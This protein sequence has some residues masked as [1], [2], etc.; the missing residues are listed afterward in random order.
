[1]ISIQT[2][3]ALNVFLEMRFIFAFICYLLWLSLI[4]QDFMG[5][6]N[7]GKYDNTIQVK[8]SDKATVSYQNFA[9]SNSFYKI[10]EP[11]TINQTSSL[12]FKISISGHKDTIIHRSYHFDYNYKFPILSI[13]IDPED[14]WNDTTGIYVKGK[15]AYW[16]DS[17]GHWENCNYQKKW[18]KTV[19]ATFIDT[20]NVVGFSQK[21]GLKIFGESTR[22]QPDKSMKIIARSEFGEGKFNYKL[23]PQ[24]NLSSFKQLAIR[25]SG[26]DY[27]NTR[28]KDVLSAHLARNLG[29]DYMAWLPVQLYV[30]GEHWGVYNLREKINEHFIAEN[31]NAIEDSVNII[32]GRWVRQEG[33]S[34]DFMKMYYWFASLDTMTNSNYEKAKQFLNIRNYIN[35]RVFQ[36]FINNKD[37]RGNIRYYNVSGEADKRFKMILYDTDLGYGNYNFNYLEKCISPIETNWYNPIWSTMYLSKLMQHQEFKEEFATQFAH[38]M[39]TALHKDTILD[40]IQLYEDLYRD[41]LPRSSEGRPKHFKKHYFPLVYWE[42]KVNEL[43]SYAKLRHKPMWQH[44]GQTL[45]LKGTFILKVVGDSGAIKINENYPIRLPYEGAYFSDISLSLE[46]IPTEG[47]EFSHWENQDTN[48][49]LTVKGNKDTLVVKPIFKLKPIILENQSVHSENDKQS[50][51]NMVVEVSDN[52]FASETFL[53]YLAYGLLSIGFLLLI[54]FIV[55]TIWDKKTK[56]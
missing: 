33:S 3:F 25:T 11:I 15:Y 45:G 27:S 22:R 49:I 4:S 10:K 47:H 24:K 55:M 43:K 34:K 40:A 16:S 51:E 31:H 23:F 50:T 48:A 7:S 38:I 30:N 46:A 2:L 53:Y 44:L 8:P 52:F 12:L 41:E 54:L 39:N 29:V 28:F 1:M 18:E 26:N 6:P 9:V 35:Y 17:T 36:I 14:L 56:S 42:E 13:V 37:S 21:S 32:M 20:N 19:Y 5:I